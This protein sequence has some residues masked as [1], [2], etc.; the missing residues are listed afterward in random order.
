MYGLP[1]MMCHTSG[2]GPG[3]P[4]PDQH[5]VLPGHRLLDVPELEHVRLA[6]LVLR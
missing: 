1:A 5:V 3:R 2:P 4:N 6:V